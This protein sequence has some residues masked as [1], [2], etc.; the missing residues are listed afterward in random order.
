MRHG[1][2]VWSAKNFRGKG[3]GLLDRIKGWF[4]PSKAG[5][6]LAVNDLI[7]TILRTKP[8]LVA[9]KTRDGRSVMNTE[10][11]PRVFEA[12]DAVCAERVTWAYVYPW[13]PDAGRQADWK[14]YLDQQ[15]YR[16]ASD[17]VAYRAKRV[18]LNAEKQWFGVEG[19]LAHH[20]VERLRWWL[21]ELGSG[22]GLR[23][24]RIG[25]S[26]YALPSSFRRYPW[27]AWC[28]ATDEAW[29]QLYSG[30][31]IGYER[32]ALRSARKHAEHG[33]RV[34]V[35][36]GPLYR[37]AEQMRRFLVGVSAM[38]GKQTSPGLG[39][40]G[41]TV[42]PLAVWWA[43]DQMTQDREAVLLESA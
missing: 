20:L 21:H 34:V 28:R 37:G 16:I 11:A 17:A 6:A 22:K 4:R 2:W 24:P 3:P 23:T 42:E 8:A 40:P 39:M 19:A 38:F 29:P 5:G 30:G 26:S 15:A 1:L 31:S 36:S 32:R 25:W 12:A 18:V 9:V 14:P 13:N 35:F 10:L 41:V 27:G 43:A 7:E 33:A